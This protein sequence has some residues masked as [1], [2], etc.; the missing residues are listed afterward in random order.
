MTK[1]KIDYTRLYKQIMKEEGITASKV[2]GYISQVARRDPSTICR[3]KNSGELFPS[4]VIYRLSRSQNWDGDMIGW[5]FF[6]TDK[7][8]DHA[9]D[10]EAI[11]TLK[12]AFTQ[13]MEGATA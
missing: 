13:L 2:T 5:L 12:K 6:D 1:P 3:Y 4:D 8:N 10:L 7:K 9:E 11:S